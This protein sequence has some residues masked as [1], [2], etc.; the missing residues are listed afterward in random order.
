MSGNVK[1]L[2]GPPGTGKTTTLLNEIEAL[3]ANGVSPREIAFVS[4]TKA[5]VKE[6]RDRAATRFNLDP[7]EFEFFKTIHAMA[8][9]AIGKRPM[10]DD[11]QW[12]AFGESFSYSFSEEG[13]EPTLN[14][15]EDGDCLKSLHSLCRAKRCSV[16]EAILHSGDV[17]PHITPEMVDL[18]AERLGAW[19]REHQ[20]IDF[21]DQ[22]EMAA[23]IEWRPPVR[24][25]FI[26]EAQDNSR[27]QNALTKKWFWENSRC[28]QVKYAG[29]DDQAI[30]VWSGA[31]NGA[32]VRL[33]AK[34]AP[35]FL[36]QS[37]RVPRLAHAVGQSI[38]RDNLN[39]VRKSYLPREAD[40]S[41]R[42]SLD[43]HGSLE[44]C[45]D[46]AMVLV[47]NVRF[48]ARYRAACIEAGRLFSCEI[49]AFSP[50]DKKD[51]KEA[52]H[53]VAAWRNGKNA[54]AVGLMSLLKLTPSRVDDVAV[55]PRGAKAAAAKNMDPVPVW[56]AREQFNLHG[57]VEVCLR[58]LDPF[59]LAMKIP[60]EER[61][62]L[63]LVLAR[64]P[65][66][67]GG[68]I[69]ITTIHRS[70]GREAPTVV[71][72]ADMARRTFRKWR[73]GPVDAREEE[74]RVQYVAVT[75]TKDRLIIERP[76]ENMFFPYEQHLGRVA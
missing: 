74:R 18:F 58:E 2:L 44:G 30:Y 68:K 1:V 13:E 43:A 47:R 17:P 10:M 14:F 37:R 25:A 69:T 39:R 12:K 75:R 49:G 46:E 40:G 52:F 35:Q 23:A 60:P 45:G 57:L 38:I 50:L 16:A 22:L 29:D 6:A 33:S 59:A 28:E 3:L 32:L 70:K 27:M 63:E 55:L 9:R 54:S 71:V 51:T 48:A 21:G 26:D 42:R 53:A 4:F 8:Y 5:A 73:S 7:E 41:L 36:E 19:K 67:E 66:L 56:R 20:V 11:P 65:L 15:S 34:F 31:D 24:F 62:Y 72:S 76:S 61:R 64:D